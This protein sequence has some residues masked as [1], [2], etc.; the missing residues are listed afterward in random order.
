MRR[1]RHKLGLLAGML[2]ALLIT[3][4]LP[5]AVWAENLE[6]TAKIPYEVPTQ[7]ATIQP[8][9]NGSTSTDAVIIVS[10]TCQAMSPVTIV[11]VWRGGVL[12]GSTI[13]S[14]SYS[15]Q[16][17]LAEGENQLI[18]RTAN[19]DGVYGPDST[20]TTVRL[21]LP[22][23]IPP[24]TNPGNSDFPDVA[25]KARAT[26][27]AARSG[28]RLGATQPFSVLSGSTQTDIILTVSGGLPGYKLSI[29]W[30]NGVTEQ[31]RLS[32]GGTFTYTARYDRP[33]TYI[34]HAQIVDDQGAW[35]EF[36]YAMVSLAQPA[37]TPPARIE[38]RDGGSGLSTSMPLATGALA[39]TGLVGLATFLGFRLG[40]TEA[41]Q[42]MRQRVKSRQ[43]WPGKRTGK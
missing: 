21:Q 19:L 38:S 14:G 37:A 2:T 42:A 35:A 23:V 15:M 25:E 17:M 26:G 36:S 30:G 11:S 43:S 40:E 16:I 41:V 39:V 33:G 5:A 24:A 9:L 4:S 20:V 28:L 6:V 1:L 7:A 31:H 13:C 12:L 10:G 18:A 27:Q 8:A 32:A 22:V 34:V 29:N 3:G